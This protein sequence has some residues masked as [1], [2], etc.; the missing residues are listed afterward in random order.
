MGVD[1]PRHRTEVDDPGI[2]PVWRQTAQIDRSGP[3]ADRLRAPAAEI[4]VDE[5]GRRIRAL[6]DDRQLIR[7]RLQRRDVDA[8]DR[9]RRSGPW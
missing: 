7:E 1:L 8:I 4:L 3:I 6:S 5:E 2:R 9:A